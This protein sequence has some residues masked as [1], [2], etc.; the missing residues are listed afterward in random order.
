MERSSR[1]RVAVLS[2]AALVT[3]ALGIGSVAAGQGS[4]RQGSTPYPPP[5]LTVPGCGLGDPNN[6][7]TGLPGDE[8]CP[9]PPSP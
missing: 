4:D 9:N 8:V 5:A 2:I 6:Q 7:H 1:N 3:G